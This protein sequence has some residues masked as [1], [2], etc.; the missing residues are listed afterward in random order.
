[1]KQNTKPYL[2]KL[3][4]ASLLTLTLFITNCSTHTRH[5]RL[6]LKLIK[7]NNVILNQVKEERETKL[8]QSIIKIDPALNEAE[9]RLMIALK[10]VI[11]SNKSLEKEFS[12]V[13]KKENHNERSYFSK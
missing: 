12:A 5:K 9:K 6:A 10:A 11:N 2:T 1:M 4:L 7:N 8:D 13:A 3:K